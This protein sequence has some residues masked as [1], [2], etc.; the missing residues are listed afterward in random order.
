[1]HACVTYAQ[2]RKMFG[3]NT[4]SPMPISIREF[5][6]CSI[7]SLFLILTCGGLMF[8]QILILVHGMAFSAF[9]LRDPRKLYSLMWILG[10]ACCLT[11]F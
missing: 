9:C 1:M 6:K 11:A 5:C 4:L 2:T 10:R 3:L 8:I 7:N